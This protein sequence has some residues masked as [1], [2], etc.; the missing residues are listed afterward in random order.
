VVYTEI[1]ASFSIILSSPSFGT[2]KFECCC[3]HHSLFSTNFLF[4]FSFRF[5]FLKKFVLF[6]F[7]CFILYGWAL[8]IVV[9]IVWAIQGSGSTKHVPNDT[10]QIYVFCLWL[11][12]NNFL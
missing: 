7:F 5:N 4:Y 8:I 10:H 3:H 6:T 12:I 1:R 2:T 11:L 9:Q